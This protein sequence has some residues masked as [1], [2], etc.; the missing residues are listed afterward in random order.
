MFRRKA[1]PI[2]VGD[3]FVK[4]GGNR[5]IWTVMDIADA[6]ARLVSKQLSPEHITISVC[7]LGDRALFEPFVPEPIMD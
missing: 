7:A 3:S 4:T 5:K 2:R 1:P 6:H